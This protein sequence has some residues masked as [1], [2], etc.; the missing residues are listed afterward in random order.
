MEELLFNASGE[1]DIIPSSRSS[2]KDFDFYIGK[3]RI[4]NRKL[5]SRLDD[6]S[7]WVEFEATQT[8][9]KALSGLASMDQFY[10]SLSG[11]VF[12]GI[13]IRL[14]NPK[15]RLWSIYWADSNN[16]TMDKPVVGSFDKNIGHFYTRDTHQG[17]PIIMVFH[18]DK[19][20]N[21]NP[22]W[23]QAWSADN[24]KTWEWNWFMYMSRMN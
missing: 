12:E 22:V 2:H 3:W 7:E 14:F 6:C 13:T 10:T 17:K 4:K 20:D 9:H 8:N 11:K 18:W 21:D 19:T 1:L 24:G 15:S 5:K 16:G 23:S